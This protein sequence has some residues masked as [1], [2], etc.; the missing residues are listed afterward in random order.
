MSQIYG[1]GSKQIAMESP[2]PTGLSLEAKR[3]YF[4]T[5]HPDTGEVVV[6]E[7]PHEDVLSAE[8]KYPKR[9]NDGEEENIITD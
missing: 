3:V 8:I 4:I 1:C 7:V 5:L 6:H 9:K 2:P